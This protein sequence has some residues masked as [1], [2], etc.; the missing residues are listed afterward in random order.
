MVRAIECA[1]RSLTRR[2][3]L[4]NFPSLNDEH[5]GIAE[6]DL[7]LFELVFVEKLRLTRE[8]PNDVEIEID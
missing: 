1:A 5:L 6:L 7:M 3:R 2:I 4:R 8:R